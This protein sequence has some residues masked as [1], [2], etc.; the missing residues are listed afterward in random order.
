MALNQ[1]RLKSRAY[2]RDPLLRV[3]AGPEVVQRLK[4]VNLAADLNIQAP[5]TKRLDFLRTPRSTILLSLIAFG[6]ARD[7][8]N[9]D[10]IIRVLVS[11]RLP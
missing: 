9:G 3:G 10:H 1:R 4:S 8:T 11:D 2:G 5:G 7:T 6:R